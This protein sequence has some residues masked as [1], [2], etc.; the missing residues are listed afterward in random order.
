[1]FINGKKARSGR[2]WKPLLLRYR[3]K[4]FD[5]GRNTVSPV[6]KDYKVPFA[7]QG[8]IEQVTIELK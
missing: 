3:V 4:P 6:P 7:F 5:I 8:R 2:V 1:V